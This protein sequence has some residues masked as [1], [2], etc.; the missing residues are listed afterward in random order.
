M[1]V[2]YLFLNILVSVSH[3]SALS[4]A[5]AL[6]EPLWHSWPLFSQE[7]ELVQLTV[8]NPSGILLSQHIL[9]DNNNLPNVNMTANTKREQSINWL[10]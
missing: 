7:H 1:Y 8:P 2:L 3:S 4:D 9:N 10:S 5:E 6:L